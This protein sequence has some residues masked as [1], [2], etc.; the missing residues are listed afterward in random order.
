MTTIRYLQGKDFSFEQFRDLYESCSLGKRRPIED[1]ARFR[2]MLE[3]ANLIWTAWDENLLV[4]ISRC[5][6]DFT[7]VLYLADLAIRET[8]QRKGIG[9]ELIKKTKSSIHEKAK[10]V[11]MAA[12]S[13]I[14]YYPHLGFERH[15]EGWILV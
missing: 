15:P 2:G 13:A 1:E 6:T 9:K 5:L 4:G 3:N 12:P 7:Y 14:G 10:I 8:H 11:L